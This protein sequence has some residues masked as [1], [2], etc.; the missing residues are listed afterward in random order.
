MAVPRHT[1][2]GSRAIEQTLNT[3]AQV[4]RLTQVPDNT[5]GFTD[6]YTAVKSYKCSFVAQGSIAKENENAVQ[7]QVQMLWIFTFPVGSDIRPTD[8]IF[9][10]AQSR[11]FEV[12]QPAT[13]SLDLAR[14]V[15]CMELV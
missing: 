9:I 11:T 7:V 13:G 6:T 4:L 1:G 5:G 14:R 12:V 15:L 8:R 3:T 2:R 10:P